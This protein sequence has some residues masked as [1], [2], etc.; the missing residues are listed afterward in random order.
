MG[1]GRVRPKGKGERDASCES[2][3]LQLERCV[4]KKPPLTHAVS[5]NSGSMGK[6]RQGEGGRGDQKTKLPHLTD[7]IPSALKVL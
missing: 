4:N 1:V 2:L 6:G 7:L 3:K 5:C